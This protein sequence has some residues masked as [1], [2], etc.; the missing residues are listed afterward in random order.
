MQSLAQPSLSLV[1]SKELAQL[2]QPGRTI[3]LLHN[4]AKLSQ[5]DKVCFTFTHRPLFMTVLR[6][7]GIKELRYAYCLQE[8]IMGCNERVEYKGSQER[9]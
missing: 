9:E 4:T 5:N 2:S 7:V 6:R 1:V 3:L 8:K